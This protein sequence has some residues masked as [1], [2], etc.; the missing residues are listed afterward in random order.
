MKELLKDNE[1]WKIP[2]VNT[3]CH[4]LKEPFFEEISLHKLLQMTYVSW[5]IPDSGDSQEGHALYFS[6][7]KTNSYFYW[8]RR[9]VETLYG[10]GRKLTAKNWEWFD[11]TIQQAYST[12][13]SRDI[14]L[15]TQACRY[16]AILLDDYNNPGSD[17]ELPP[18]MRPVF[19]CDMFLCGYVRGKTDEN[20]NHAYDYFSHCPDSL[21]EY[22]AEM[23][24]AVQTAVRKG[25]VGL[26]IA[27]AYERSLEFSSTSF[28]KAKEAFGREDASQE[29]IKAFG[30]YIMF[31]LAKIAAELSIPIQIHTGLG[32]LS[33]SRAIGLR[34]LI[35]ANPETKFDIF[36]GS[37][38]WCSDAL[39]LAHNFSNVYLDLCWMPLISTTRSISFLRE[40]L[41][42]IEADRILW[43]CDTWTSEESY[44]ARMAAHHC[45]LQVLNSFIEED[46]LNHEEALEYAENILS[47]NAARLYGL[48]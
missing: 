29:Q 43:G 34:D 25:A 24:L 10:N 26:K 28:L 45:L 20:H 3:H 47:G 37:Y 7:M 38:P 42:L 18:L 48:F 31:E 1:L 2:A 41:E 21:D 12:A 32:A 23:K 44:G 14:N 17:H 13:E 46:M 35:A 5:L 8:W 27:I 16:R 33:Q 9:A 11:N 36:H 30:D 19:R 4:H 39:G 22:V 15:L 6:K 40:A